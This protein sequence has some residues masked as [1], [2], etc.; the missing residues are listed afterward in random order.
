MFEA[1]SLYGLA[2]LSKF[3]PNSH[4]LLKSAESLKGTFLRKG[5]LYGTFERLRRVSQM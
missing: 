2:T 5:L 4:P 3:M 1:K